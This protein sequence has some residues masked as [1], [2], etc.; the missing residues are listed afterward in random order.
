MRRDC[1]CEH[2]A[3]NIKFDDSIAKIFEDKP[4]MIR[5]IQN[6]IEL[7]VEKIEEGSGGDVPENVLT[8][9]DIKD[10]TTGSD[11]LWSSSKIDT[12]IQNVIE[13]IPASGVGRVY[14]YEK[15]GETIAGGEIFNNYESN[16]AKG[17]YAH[18]EG[19][20]TFANG[21]ASHTEGSETGCGPGT[22]TQYAE[23]RQDGFKGECAHAEGQDTF[24]LGIA[25]HSEGDGGKTYGKYSHV[26]GYKCETGI[27][28]NG[29]LDENEQLINKGVAAHAEGQGTKAIG[30]QSHSG[31]RFSEA[32]GDYSFSHGLSVIASYASEIAFGKYN[33]SNPDT[34]F[35]L[36]NGTSDDDRSNAF[37]VKTSGNV[38]SSGYYADKTGH[39][40]VPVVFITEA[41]YEALTVKEPVIYAITDTQVVYPPIS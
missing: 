8:K 29:T 31:G 17:E 39:F 9:D 5:N 19:A 26:E 2:S 36:G 33:Q 21:V 20:G 18:A 7:L 4:T 37:E 28:T 15:D 34:L 38:K 13:Q 27:E 6:A 12:E 16:T 30:N 40:L 3:R 32:N 14:T 11:F 23:Q 22:N 25:S 41:E 10:N 1:Q 24:S 35:S